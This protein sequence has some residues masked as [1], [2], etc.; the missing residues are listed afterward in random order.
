MIGIGG[1]FGPILEAVERLE[2]QGIPVAYHQPRT[3][4]PML[5]DTIDFIN[6]HERVFVV[7]LNATAQIAKLFIREG[8]EADRISNVLRFDGEPMRPND[9]V[10]PV[11]EYHQHRQG[12]RP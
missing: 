5:P 10:A 7:E 9:V 1:T 3:L 6:S 12:S 8:A 2:A 11:S 4:W